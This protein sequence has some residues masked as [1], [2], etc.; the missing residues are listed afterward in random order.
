[1]HGLIR[2][3][4]P[5]LDLDAEAAL[6]RLLVETIGAGLVASAHDCAE[7]GLAVTLSECCFDTPFG[8][9]VDVPAVDG[10]GEAWITAAT[11]FAESASRVVVSVP[12]A[13]LAAFMERAAR[14]HVPASVIGRVGGDRL[15]LAISGQVVVDERCQELEHIWESAIESRF[16]SSKAIA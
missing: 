6:Q 5:A 14:A 10:L 15:R 7:G 9:D 2:G 8:V 13:A 3:V 4:P 1:M 12:G 11:L 16:E